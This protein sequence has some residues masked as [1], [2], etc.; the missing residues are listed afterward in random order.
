M[1]SRHVQVKHN[2]TIEPLSFGHKTTAVS[3]HFPASLIQANHG[4]HH[5]GYHD[6]NMTMETYLNQVNMIDHSV[7]KLFESMSIA[8]NNNRLV[9]VA[10][11]LSDLKLQA[12]FYNTSLPTHY[13]FR[14]P[15]RE[16]ITIIFW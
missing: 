10:V 15:F 12:I 2:Q 13:V 7:N 6:D 16:A 8:Y 11:I 14:L 3:G 5:L 1:T 4:Y 9:D